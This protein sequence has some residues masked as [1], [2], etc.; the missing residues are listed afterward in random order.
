[1]LRLPA[2][3]ISRNLGKLKAKLDGCHLSDC[4]L[5]CDLLKLADHKL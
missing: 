2:G 1:M 4:Y 5:S 3:V